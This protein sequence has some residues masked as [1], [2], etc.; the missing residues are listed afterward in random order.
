[1]LFRSLTLRLSGRDQLNLRF[2]DYRYSAQNGLPIGRARQTQLEYAHA[3]RSELSDLIGSAF[4]SSYAFEGGVDTTDPRAVEIK[5]RLFATTPV[6][7]AALAPSSFK[8]YGLRLSTNTRHITDY[9]RALRPFGSVGLLHNS[10]VGAGYDYSLGLAGSVLGND[11]FSAMLR[12]DKGG[13]G[14]YAKTRQFAL[15]YRYLF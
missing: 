2:D 12:E 6:D 10:V 3:F 11:H 15:H 4:A 13:T 8:L 14:T 5:Q 9:T 1:M 7:A